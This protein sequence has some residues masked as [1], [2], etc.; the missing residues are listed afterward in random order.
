MYTVDNSMKILFYLFIAVLVFLVLDTA[1]FY[2]LLQK[3]KK[4]AA[5]SIPFQRI[6]SH[7]EMKVLV[8]GDSTAVG[9]GA[10]DSVETTA[11]R[12]GQLYPQAEI[13]NLAE[14]GL[15]VKDLLVQLDSLDTDDHFSLILIQ[16][17][18]NDIIRLTPMVEV[19]KDV[20]QILGR[21]T[22]I[23]DK[24]VI[25]HSGNVGEAPFFPLYVRPLFSN[26]SLQMREIYKNLNQ[27]HGS[28]YVDLIDSSVGETFKQDPKKYYA[29]DFLHLSGEGY[30]LWFQEIA[31]KL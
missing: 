19:E 18:A 4:L 6:D 28:E 30:G 2:L 20:D 31:K 7:A 24:V 27:K 16:V 26:R 9:T 17:G 11:G 8:L 15:Q 22:Q 25:L 10:T 23:A 12:L 3:S 1:R 13:R 14:N 5:E 29:R 21:I